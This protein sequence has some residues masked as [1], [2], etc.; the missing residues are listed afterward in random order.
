MLGQFRRYEL[1][2]L[3]RILRTRK[4]PDMPR[5]ARL[6]SRKRIAGTFVC[7]PYVRTSFKIQQRG[8]NAHGM[9]YH[10]IDCIAIYTS[11]CI[12]VKPS[13]RG[14]PNPRMDENQG[15]SECA[16]G[17]RRKAVATANTNAGGGTCDV[18]GWLN[19]VFC[20]LFLPSAFRPAT[21][22]WVGAF[23]IR[24]TCS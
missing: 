16:K 7:A 12:P 21:C 11:N 13:R 15:R 20:F 10:G 9:A 18:C 2:A 8:Y 5:M 22:L 24:P 23:A 14:E 3:R 1:G 4:Q 6:W 17:K 19:L